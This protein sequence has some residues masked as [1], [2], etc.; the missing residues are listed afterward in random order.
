[1]F[2]NIVLKS[3]HDPKLSVFWPPRGPDPIVE[4]L[5]ST[6]QSTTG[7]LSEA[8][9]IVSVYNRKHHSLAWSAI[10][11]F[12]IK[13]VYI[14]IKN[15]NKCRYVTNS[16][17]YE[18]RSPLEWHLNGPIRGKAMHWARP[19]LYSVTADWPGVGLFLVPT[20]LNHSCSN[21]PSV[22]S[23]TVGESGKKSVS[24]WVK[25]RHCRELKQDHIFKCPFGTL[26]IS[27]WYYLLYTHL[28]HIY[29]S[30]CIWVA[31]W[32]ICASLSVILSYSRFLL[33]LE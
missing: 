20:C 9:L 4:N 21:S 14:S 30:T 2:K 17:L 29:S 3:C 24:H 25:V 28:L 7:L 13:K 10:M 32:S 12:S 18:L 22:H 23:Q 8:Y 15:T 6:A 26:L 5:R 16:N 1:M 33:L 19:G 31:F 11:I 27:I